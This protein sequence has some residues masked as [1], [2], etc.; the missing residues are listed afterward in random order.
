MI[1]LG[2]LAA[3]DDEDALRSTLQQRLVFATQSAQ[4]Y[5]FKTDSPR[6][7]E[8]QLHPKPLLRW[9]NQVVREDDGMLFLWV[10]SKTARP[11]AAA[12]FFLQGPVWHHEFQSLSAG[13][14]QVKCEGAKDWSWQPKTPGIVFTRAVE[15]EPPADSAVQRLRQMRGLAELFTGAVDPG[16]SGK[17]EGPHELRLL[18]TPV[19]RYAAKESGTLDGALFAFV[20]G[21]NPEVLMLVEANKSA[22]GNWEWR[23]GFA[24][25]TSFQLRVKRGE[26]VV[27]ERDVAEVPTRDRTSD[28]HFR[29]KAVA[30]RSAD[31]EVSDK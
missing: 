13:S 24:P 31:I 12:Q 8:C 28:Y 9:D 7:G 2:L 26:K 15:M 27:F 16:R 17:F 25:M 21:T 1:L 30:D 3:P 14:F 6:G 5:H 11:V 10:E 4:R 20:Q 23:Y 19:Y 18:T 29:F 22:A